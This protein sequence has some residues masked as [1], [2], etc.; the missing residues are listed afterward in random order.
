MEYETDEFPVYGQHGNPTFIY[1]CHWCGTE[2]QSR[3]VK[4]P[5]CSQNCSY[6]GRLYR[7]LLHA[8][9]FSIMAYILVPVSIYLLWIITGIFPWL[10]FIA[11]LIS[12][13]MSVKQFA[14]IRI[15]RS[16]R[17]ESKYRSL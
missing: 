16:M 12:P 14:R 10:Y 4:G 13:Y 8:I 15:G 5:Y 9:G 2:K 7:L 11:G 3:G 17:I 6:A 1:G